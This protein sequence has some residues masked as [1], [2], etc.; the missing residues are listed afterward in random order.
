MDDEIWRY[1]R[2]FMS[3]VAVSSGLECRLYSAVRMSSPLVRAQVAVVQV[4]ALSTF[5]RLQIAIM[6][7]LLNKHKRLFHN[8]YNG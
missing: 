4:F 3:D 6:R 2:D 5:L 7:R 8:V 1:R